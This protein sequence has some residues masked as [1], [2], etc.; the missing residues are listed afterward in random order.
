MTRHPGATSWAVCGFSMEG[1]DFARRGFDVPDA[2]VRW[3]PPGASWARARA[4]VDSIRGQ[5]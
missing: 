3:T 5:R 4:L 2:P 1:W